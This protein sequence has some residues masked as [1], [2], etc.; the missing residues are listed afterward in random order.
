M[1]KYFIILTIVLTSILANA[2][3]DSTNKEKGNDIFGGCGEQM[4]YFAGGAEARIK[5]VVTNAIYTERARKENVSGRVY[6]SFV[7]DV[8]GS[9]VEPYIL[10]GLHPDL[11]SIS[12]IIVKKM[13]AWIPAKLRGKPIKCQFNMPIEFNLKDKK[14]KELPV[15]SKYWSKKGKK[16]FLEKCLQEFGKN[17]KNILKYLYFLQLF[18]LEL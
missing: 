11:D 10:R 6:V 8:D 2:Q 7:V 1:S 5:Y 3:V 18:C 16:H 14:G 17:Q 4:P 9:I 13:P 12:I 15:P